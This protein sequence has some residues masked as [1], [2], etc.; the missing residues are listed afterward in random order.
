MLLILALTA[1]VFACKKKVD[2][3]E[4]T[5]ATSE[6]S[7]RAVDAVLPNGEENAAAANSLLTLLTDAGLE[8]A[9]I[10]AVLFS[11]TENDTACADAF[12]D[13]GKASF[14]KEHFVSY[15]VALQIAANAV[16]PEVAGTIFF[17]AASAANDDLPYTLS[18]C[19]K[20]ASLILSDEITLGTESLDSL[21]D[22]EYTAA[23]EK[24]INTALITIASSLKKA[25]GIS[26][27]AK[28]YLYSLAMETIDDL[29]AD[30]ESELSEQTRLLIEKGRRLLFTL[31]G[32]LKNGYDVILTATADFLSYADA[33]L[34]FGLP[35]E[36]KDGVIYYG[37]YYDDPDNWRTVVIS[38]EEYEAQSGDYDRYVKI[39]GTTKGFTV[40]GTFVPVSDEDAALADR[41][42]RLHTAYRAYRAFPSEKVDSFLSVFHSI[43]TVLSEEPDF[44]ASLLDRT[45]HESADTVVTSFDRQAFDRMIDTLS[46]LSA[47]DATDGV[48]EN[49]RTVAT[50]AITAFE[51]YLHGY[52]PTVY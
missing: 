28:Q 48:S 8:E 14:S 35:Y 26:D 33:R 7:R 37:C 36:K 17:T 46:T 9:E 15:R 32:I 52:F 21:L 1:S 4:E 24:K 12:V 30:S 34:F 5:I 47:F 50:Q 20:I 16:S 27:G 43:L 40:N 51:S 42:Y 31:A 38:K 49:E 3:S 44:L 45:T 25:V 41:V 10:R 39:S 18:D 6:L 22:G 23:K 13:L 29:F 2:P 11:F 19:Q